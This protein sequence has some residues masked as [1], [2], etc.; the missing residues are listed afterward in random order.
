MFRI[1]S[2]LTT[3][4]ALGIIFAPDATLNYVQT[5]IAAVK[6]ATGIGLAQDQLQNGFV[7]AVNEGKELLNQFKP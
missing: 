1:L 7:N 4:M 3:I 6:N 5:V 2:I